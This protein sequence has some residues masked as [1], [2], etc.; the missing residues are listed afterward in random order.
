MSTELGPLYHWSPRRVRQQI[1]KYGLLPSRRPA[2]ALILNEDDG[3]RQPMVCFATT[4]GTAWSH[5]NGVWKLPG[6]WDLWEVY[7]IDADEVHVM[8]AWGGRITEVRV[9]NRIYKRRLHW[10]GERTVPR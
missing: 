3:F 7:P 8:P 1:N 5:S 2:S 9:A 10:V 4:A 6:T